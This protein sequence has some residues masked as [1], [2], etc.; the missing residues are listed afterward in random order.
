MCV[1][2]EGIT[3]VSKTDYVKRSVSNHKGPIALANS[4]EKTLANLCER[5]CRIFVVNLEICARGDRAVVTKLK[6]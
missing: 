1:L 5:F 3:S 2:L 4:C 6:K